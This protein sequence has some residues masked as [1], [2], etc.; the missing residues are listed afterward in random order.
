MDKRGRREGRLEEEGR[1]VTIFSKVFSSHSAEKYRRRTLLFFERVRV[2]K[3]FLIE[4]GVSQF[5]ME[6]LL[7]HS[8]EKIRTGTLLCFTKCL[9]QKI[10]SI[11]GEREG[12]ARFSFKSFLSQTAKNFLEGTF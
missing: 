1:S 11:R 10:N 7:S 6:N 9:L 4:R 12:M 5:W 2:S 3:T 8:T